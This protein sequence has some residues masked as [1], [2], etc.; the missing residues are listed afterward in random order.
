MDLNVTRYE[1]IMAGHSASTGDLAAAFA[2]ASNAARV[3]N[4]TKDPSKIAI[5]D[6]AAGV[7]A[8]ALVGFII[9]MFREAHDRK[10]R[11]LRFLSRDGQI[12]YELA[13][14]LG[15]KL[16]IEMD[17]EYVHSSRLTWSLAASNP[18]SLPSAEWLFNS[19]MKSNADDLCARLGLSMEEYRPAL[20]EAGVSL[21]SDVRADST[22]QLAA[23]RQF[24]SRDDVIRS[25]EK[26]IFQTRSILTDYAA[27]HELADEDT[28]LVDAGW[29][30][31]MVGSL[32]KICEEAG[33]ARPHLLL[34][35]HEPRAT[36][37]TDPDRVDAYMYNT[38][39]GAGLSW[40]VADA[41]FIVETFCMGDHGIVAGFE[42]S[43]SG[44]VEVVLQTDTNPAAE[45]WGIGLYRSTVYAFCDALDGG[46]DQEVRPLIHDVMDA[47]WVHPTRSEA[48]A[49]GNYPYDSDPAGT[50]ARRL[51]RP[52]TARDACA[53][54]IRRHLVRGDRAWLAGSV[55]MSGRLGKIAHALFTAS[56][57]RVGAP[58]TD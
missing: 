23:F 22:E 18:K 12:L 7:A 8:P 41:P 31:R 36:G 21:E 26:R 35:G 17:L 25:T 56:S 55:A 28:G 47:F 32:I 48:Q 33:M 42:R 13:R 38:A 45:R 5:R 54:F 49:W 11:R 2:D 37:W 34:W 39:T 20:V 4:M 29:T 40:R 16:G 50:A 9:W 19:F 14:R 15:P 24:L 43:P 1:Q 51:A 27:Q 10:L 58:A 6:V 57:D 3:A 46:F 44:T 53:A 30:G 52:F